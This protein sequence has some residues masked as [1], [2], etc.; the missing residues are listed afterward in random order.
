MLVR[1]DTIRPLEHKTA[2]GIVVVHEYGG[3]NEGMDLGVALIS[4]NYPGEGRYTRNTKVETMT[5]FVLSGRCI[6]T[7][8]DDEPFDISEGDCVF[9]GKNVLYKVEVAEG[10]HV[11]VLMA[12]NPSW[13]PDQVE[14][15]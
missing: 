1:K 10:D 2:D 9:I 7:F 11:E 15:L 14:V 13:S 12:S 3:L 6:F 8:K 4:G 5:F